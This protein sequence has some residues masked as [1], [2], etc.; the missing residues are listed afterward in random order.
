MWATVHNAGG[1]VAQNVA[2]LLV[3]EDAF[4]RT[5]LGLVLPG[6][7]VYFASNVAPDPEARAVVYTRTVDRRELVWN[8][9]NER[10]ELAGEAAAYPEFKDLWSAFYD[11]EV[12]N[13]DRDLGRLLRG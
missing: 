13:G 12:E 5:V 3:T 6:E 1:G 9:A 11:D 8:L 10:R 7:S 2:V 4:A